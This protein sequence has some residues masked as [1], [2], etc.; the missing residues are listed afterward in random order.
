MYASEAEF[1]SA[2][3]A[4]KDH[5]H[6][7]TEDG[8]NVAWRTYLNAQKTNLQF[9]VIGRI[10]K[11]EPVGIDACNQIVPGI[12]PSMKINMAVMNEDAGGGSIMD[13]SKW[14]ML[15]NDAWLL[16]GIHSRTKFYLASPRTKVN[17]INSDGL[18]ANQLTVT[19]RE[20]AG[21]KMFGYRVISMKIGE[22]AIHYDASL[23]GTASFEKYTRGVSDYV[24][25]DG[26]NDLI[27]PP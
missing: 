15:V 22:V 26:W 9:L 6:G 1:N 16:G 20:L 7:L 2:V 21:L 23:S 8:V 11:S 12:G 25:N 18:Y 13:S 14:T 27:G 10:L 17:I 4:C 19:G 24:K 5:Y 3:M